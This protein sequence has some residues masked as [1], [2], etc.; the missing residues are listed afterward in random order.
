MKYFALILVL[1]IFGI[2]ST[3]NIDPDTARSLV[4]W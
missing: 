1:G 4:A 2:L 3:L